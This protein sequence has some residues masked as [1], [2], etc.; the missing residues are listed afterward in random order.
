MQ[1]L[2]T[3]PKYFDVTYVINPYMEA[4]LGNVNREK[5]QEEWDALTK[6]YQDLGVN[7]GLLE[8]QENLPD[9]VFAANA[10]LTFKGPN[11]EKSV[12]ISNMEKEQRRPESPHYEAWFKENGYQVHKLPKELSFSGTGDVLYHH[13]RSLLWGGYG[14]RTSQETH[15][16]VE[17][18]T[19]LEVRSLH[20]IDPWFYD[21][22]TCLTPLNDTC[23]MIYFKAFDETSQKLIR[24]VFTDPIELTDEEARNFTCN[25]HIL[26]DRKI[27]IMNG[28]SPRVADELRKRGYE[29]ISAPTD[30]FLKA[31]GS[32]ACMK[33]ALI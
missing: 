22:D 29:I 19:G 17:R 13:D 9:M 26:N 33:M 3:T 20:L 14:F 10:A 5:A 2:R 11:G 24:S 12:L 15:R 8:G 1:I 18:I 21:L 25:S 28:R 16:E 6:I 4:G 27:V 23:A 32:V 7:Y 31:G 30:E